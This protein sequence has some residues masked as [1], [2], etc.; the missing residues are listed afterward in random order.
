MT[1]FK[2]ELKKDIDLSA[3][4]F[5]KPL[6]FIEEFFSFLKKFGVVG[7]A[8]GVVIGASVKTLVDSLVLNIINPVLAKIVGQS[9]LSGIEFQGIKFGSFLNDVINFFILMLVVYF[10][11]SFFI[12]RFLSEDELKALK[13]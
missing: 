3:K 11:I 1:T 6:N 7:L 9:N 4:V 13:L 8:L 12:K 5:S 10:A 2:E